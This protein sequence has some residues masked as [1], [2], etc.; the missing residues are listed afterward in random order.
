MGWG[1]EGEMK[2][3]RLLKKNAYPCIVKVFK[4]LFSRMI[5][6]FFPVALLLNPL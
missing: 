3:P 1:L 4:G 2:Q 5:V 6:G